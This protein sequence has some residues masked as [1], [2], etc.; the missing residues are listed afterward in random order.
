[1]APSWPEDR[2]APLEG[3]AATLAMGYVMEAGRDAHHS[4]CTRGKCGAVIVDQANQIVGRGFNSP[5]GN[6][7]S[8][9]RCDRKHEIPDTFRSDRTCCV[10]AEWRA[11]T[12]ALRA[13]GETLEGMTLYYCGADE[14]G[15]P[16]P[17][18]EPYCTICS[19]LALDAGIE[20]FVL[21]H[22]D[23]VVAYPTEL[24]NDLSFNAAKH[25]MTRGASTERTR[26]APQLQN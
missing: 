5:P 19:K 3:E 24:Y 14:N 12:D 16:R 15:E 10:H 20:L 17:S 22:E 2:P 4:P 6:L 1:M 25:R 11:I 23:G 9:C 8:Q 13:T 21:W 18:G 7:A 26:I